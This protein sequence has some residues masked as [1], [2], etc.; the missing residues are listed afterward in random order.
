[1]PYLWILRG[2][3]AG[4]FKTTKKARQF[5]HLYGGQLKRVSWARFLVRRR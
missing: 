1:M 5:Q 2:K 3:H 4:F